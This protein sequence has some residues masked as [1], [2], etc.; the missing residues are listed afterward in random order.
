M[1][2]GVEGTR[3][4]SRFEGIRD[5]CFEE[6]GEVVPEELAAI[7]YLSGADVEEVYSERASLKVVTENVRVVAL[8]GGGDALFFLELM[9]RGELIAEACGGFK[10]LGFR[11]CVHT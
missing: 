3:I 6:V 4:F 7:Y 5:G 9:Y 11:S 2:V 8:L 1:T 10:L